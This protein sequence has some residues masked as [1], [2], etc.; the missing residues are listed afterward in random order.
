MPNRLS[1]RG[2]PALGCP[3]RRQRREQRARAG[4]GVRGAVRAHQGA[5]QLR[6]PVAA[7]AALPVE[8]HVRP[9]DRVL[10]EQIGD[11]A[12]ELQAL[13]AARVVAR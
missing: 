2:K 10:V 7:G 6:L 5:P 9:V 12:G 11:A 8:H 3:P 1:R 13:G 4:R